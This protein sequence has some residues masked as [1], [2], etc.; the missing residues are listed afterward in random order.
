M[1]KSNIGKIVWRDLTVPDAG[2]LS[3]FYRQVI[4][5]EVEAVDLGDYRDFVM[6]AGG[7][8]VA[9]VCHARGSNAGLPAQWLN[10]VQV[11][12][13]EVC[14]ASCL[15]A[16]GDVIHGPRLMDGMAFCVIRDPAG[17][18]LGLIEGK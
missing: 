17:A 7:E 15:A 14:V 1:D 5:W 9:G 13:V 3:E 2:G 10:Y 4:G 11:E 8:T 18:V 12:S 6:K 16:G